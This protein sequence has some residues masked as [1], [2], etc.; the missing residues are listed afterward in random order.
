[1]RRARLFSVTR[2]RGIDQP[3]LSAKSG[4]GGGTGNAIS[5]F[6]EERR[7]SAATALGRHHHRPQTQASPS[8]ASSAKRRPLR[9]RPAQTSIRR[10]DKHCRIFRERDTFEGLCRS[11]LGYARINATAIRDA[12][13]ALTVNIQKVVHTIR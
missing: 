11:P 5:M 2:P 3:A 1:M 10:A 9:R 7:I 13:A 4:V 12:E 6:I 8:C